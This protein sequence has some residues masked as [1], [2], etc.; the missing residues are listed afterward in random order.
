[1]RTFT[2]RFR[3]RHYELD[4][5]GHLNNAVDIRLMQE[6]AIEASTEAGYS[7]QWYRDQGTG[8]VIR[9]LQI[10]YYTQALYGDE[11]EI[12]TWVSDMKRVSSHREYRIT[13]LSDGASV[14]RA[15]VNWVYIDLDNN[16]PTRVPQEFKDAFRPAGEPEELGIRLIK[17]QKTDEAYRYR[18]RR[19]VQTYELDT[20]QHVHHAVYLNWIEQV[21][22]DALR[23]SGHP[24]EKLQHEG[25]LTLQGGHDIEYFEPARDN[26]EI[27]IMSWICEMA[28][29]RGAWTHEI[30]RANTRELLARDYS[31][32]VFVDAQGKLIAPPQTVV[33]DV[34]RGPKV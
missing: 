27:E 31:L 23:H 1:M 15:R 12:T 29:V 11:L 9:R 5:L 16:Q 32:G 6:A 17:S 33:D 25:W 13:R 3:V 8:W 18:S 20:L 10:R 26:D 4:F 2:R 19:R 22:F 30:F 21:Y 7:P 14:A 28:K 34:L 24:I